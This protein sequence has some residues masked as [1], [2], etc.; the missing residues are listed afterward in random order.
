ML[1]SSLSGT[2]V[3]GFKASRA[4]EG[5]GVYPAAG[6]LAATFLTWANKPRAVLKLA[7]RRINGPQAAGITQAP[8][9]NPPDSLGDPAAPV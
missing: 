3:V 1:V 9:H 7:A 2:Q 4:P 5:A 6:L 8:E